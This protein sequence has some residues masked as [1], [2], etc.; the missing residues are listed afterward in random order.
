VAARGK[1]ECDSQYRGLRYWIENGGS[2]TSNTHFFRRLRRPDGSFASLGYGKD[3]LVEGFEKICRRRFLNVP[4]ADMAGTYPDAASQRLP[5]AV[6]HAAR[7]VLRRNQ[8]LFEAGRPPAATASFGK[9]AFC[10]TTP[11]GRTRSGCMRGACERRRA[12]GGQV[13]A[14]CGAS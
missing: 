13:A 2:R 10:C 1:V 12:G 14:Q 8:A 3:S 7:A 11:P 6:V 9:R 4:V 5:T